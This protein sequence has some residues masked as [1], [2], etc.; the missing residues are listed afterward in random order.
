MK[1][2]SFRTQ[3]KETLSNFLDSE[4]MQ[5]VDTLE[6][7][8][9]LVVA[10]SHYTE[11]GNDLFPQVLLCDNLGFALSIFQGSEAIE[12][13][14]GAKSASTMHQAL[15]RCAR[16]SQRDWVIYVHR[17]GN[18]FRYGVFRAPIAPTALGVR[19]TLVSLSQEDPDHRIIMVSQLVDK[20]VE[21][22]G[23]CSGCL[24][25]YLSATPDDTSHPRAAVENFASAASA[26]VDTD[27]KEQVDNFLLTTL[28]QALRYC[29]GALM[30]VAPHGAT[31]VIG[32]TE[33][34]V[35]LAEPIRLADIVREYNERRGD[36][37]LAK[38]DA[39]ASLLAGMVAS[40]GIVLFDE[41]AVVLGYNFF[42]QRLAGQVE[43]PSGLLG[44]ARRRAYKSL[45]NMV[46]KGILRAC[47]FQSSD[48]TSDFQGGTAK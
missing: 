25:V 35:T 22:I 23:S 40:D 21:L 3:L 1:S 2:T 27:I 6:S 29:H 13:G 46:S 34:G 43:T 47:Y 41:E 48:G 15:R 9:E 39:F 10:L 44:G 36:D 8:L 18:E 37:T 42:I 20:A 26:I 5:C 16:L 24:N 33:D 4:K 38:L 32:L 7:L 14:K 11:E 30:A 19:D 12:I 45:C 31:A 28:F 17:S